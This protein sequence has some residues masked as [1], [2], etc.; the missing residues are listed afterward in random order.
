MQQC[1]IKQDMH[2]ATHQD[3]CEAHRREHSGFCR[4]NMHRSSRPV[5][6]YMQDMQ[7]LTDNTQ[8]QI[9]GCCELAY[10]QLMQRSLSD[11]DRNIN[12]CDQLDYIMLLT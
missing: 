12:Y 8:M 4:T 1:S 9:V 7:T 10:V 3:R 5:P 2:P 11:T 6:V